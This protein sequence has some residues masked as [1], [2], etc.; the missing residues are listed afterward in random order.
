MGA[1]LRSGKPPQRGGPAR[2]NAAQH[3][4]GSRGR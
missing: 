1:P 3:H 4:S 2:G